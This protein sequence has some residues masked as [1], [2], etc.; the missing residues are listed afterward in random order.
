M[1]LAPM[2]RLN[3]SA[4]A[5]VFGASRA[6]GD[7]AGSIRA[8]MERFIADWT[9]HGADLPAGFE[10]AEDRFLVVAADEGA[11]PGGCSIDGLFNL[12]R[13]F[14]RDL[15]VALLDSTLVFYR[16]SSGT[17]CSATRAEFRELATAGAVSASTIVFDTSIDRVAA[18]R[19]GRWER[20]AGES[21]HGAAFGLKA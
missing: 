7:D 17:V 14:E 6:F 11:Q 20:P 1:S 5:W 9:A 15:G 19:D 10:L 3:G 4:K 12:M 13:V 8:T 21:W 18:Y 2:E 16:D